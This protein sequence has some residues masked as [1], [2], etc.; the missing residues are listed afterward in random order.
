MYKILILTLCTMLLVSACGGSEKSSD[1]GTNY[2]TYKEALANNDFE[3]AHNIIEQVEA[4]YLKH[5]YINTDFKKK[6]PDIT[7]KYNI[8]DAKNEIFDK[9]IRYLAADG[10]SE[11][12]ARLPF[13]F[14]EF[15]KES[16]TI[17]P[18]GKNSLLDSHDHP[19]IKY[20]SNYNQKL[21]IVF[22]LAI[23][24]GNREMANKVLSMYKP[25]MDI[26]DGMLK[27]HY[28]KENDWHD[29]FTAPDGSEL[30]FPSEVYVI[31]NYRE[32]DAAIKKYEECFGKI[33]NEFAHEDSDADL[34]QDSDH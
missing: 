1:N 34:N 27:Q 22:E 26:I 31:H 13:L 33:D 15:F 10:S 25:T 28:K 14:S 3:A 20:A 5:G 8:E 17:L 11:A 23:S 4:D 6:Y 9:E 30:I 19:Y 7:S 16:Y 12:C 2:A 21:N 32:K 24:Q 29:Y 18:E